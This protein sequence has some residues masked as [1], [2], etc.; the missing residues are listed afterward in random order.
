VRRV[1]MAPWLLLA[2][3]FVVLVGA[4][5]APLAI[6]TRYSLYR[7]EPG[8]VMAP[9]WVL[10]HYRRFLLD[11]FYLRILLTTVELALAVTAVTLVLGYPVAYALAHTRSPRR[12]ALGVTVLLIPL[13]TSVVVRSYG[14]MILLASTGVV[15]TLLLA[16]GLMARPL[17]LLF[18]PLG[19]VIALAEVLLPFMVL[20]VMPVIQGIDP[21]LEE[22]SESL[23]GG[24][25]ATF[26]HVVLPLSLPG[27]AVG[28]ILVFVLAV[29]AFATPRLVGG[30]T[31]EVITVFIHEQTMS[32]LNWPFGAATSWILLLLVLG[33]IGGQSAIIERLWR[34]AD[35]GER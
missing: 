9:A 24:A 15:N 5:A 12:R 32:L 22:A 27:I 14:W 10:D 28:A 6:L 19:V 11:P 2:P 8:G 3:S 13:M 35:S 30:P 31:I 29:G 21:A 7:T 17:Q 26:W 18:T 34:P 20:S 23:G 1:L 25:L 33:L 16:T 4:F